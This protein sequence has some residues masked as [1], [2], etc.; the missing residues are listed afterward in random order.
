MQIEADFQQFVAPD[1][2]YSKSPDFAATRLRNIDSIRR[3]SIAAIDVKLVLKSEG[4]GVLVKISILFSFYLH[5]L[6]KIGCF[7]FLFKCCFD[8]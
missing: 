4:H 3:C 2:M 5:F 1:R 7:A 6:S 8:L